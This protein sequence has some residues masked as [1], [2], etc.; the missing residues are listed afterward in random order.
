MGVYGSEIN[1]L[2]QNRL[3]SDVI[4][5]AWQFNMLCWLARLV[6]DG[7]TNIFDHW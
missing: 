5:A 4:M 6:I 1:F 7:S 2:Q 3:S